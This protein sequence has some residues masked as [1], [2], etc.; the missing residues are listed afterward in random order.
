MIGQ[1]AVLIILLL[2]NRCRLKGAYLKEA[3]KAP[4]V[5]NIAIA[6]KLLR[7]AHAVAANGSIYSERSA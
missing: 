1:K 4:K 6:H 2:A 5:I 7:Q 3:G